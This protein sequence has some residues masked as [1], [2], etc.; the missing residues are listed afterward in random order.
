VQLY[1]SDVI[2]SISE[3]VK[4]LQGFKKISLEPNEKK[5]VEFTL[6]YE[7]LFLY[8]KNMEPVVEPGTFEVLVGNSSQNIKLKGI[9]EIKK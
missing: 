4:E 5:K 2:V 8:N 1:I 7:N 9:F 3:P 6:N